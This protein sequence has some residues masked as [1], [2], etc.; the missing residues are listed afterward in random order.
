MYTPFSAGPRYVTV[1]WFT[2][3]WSYYVSILKYRNCIGQRF[4]MDELKI[5]IAHIV[6][7]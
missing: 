6:N 2:C 4:A 5:A 1:N 7:R 3:V